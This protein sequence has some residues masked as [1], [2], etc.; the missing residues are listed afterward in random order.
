MA[1]NGSKT[2]TKCGE[3]K[4]IIEFY[5][6]RTCKDGHSPWCKACDKEKGRKWQKANPEKVNKK[7]RKWQKA[8]REKVNEAAKK[9]RKANPE[10]INRKKARERAQKWRKENSERKAIDVKNRKIKKKNIKGIYTEKDIQRLFSQQG[11]LCN[12]CGKKLIRYR[13]K[14]YHVDHIK[15]LS[16][17]GS[18]R[19]D[20]LQLLCPFCN[21][22][23]K[24]KDPIEWAREN[25]RLF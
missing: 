8:N 23:K 12:T 19:P 1:D 18:N 10:K 2:C 17:G 22:S 6:N 11:G 4:P 7:N 14:Q 24:D 13:K 16:K 5:K 25:G 15:P 3:T 20:N 21:L 9:W